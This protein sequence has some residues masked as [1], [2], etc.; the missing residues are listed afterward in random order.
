MIISLEFKI[1]SK[2]LLTMKSLSEGHSVSIKRIKVLDTLKNGL[3]K[4]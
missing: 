4:T 2:K 3:V 1:H